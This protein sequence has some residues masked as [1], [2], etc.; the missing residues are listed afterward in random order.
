M[1]KGVA[2]YGFKSGILPTARS[3]LKHPTIKQTSLLDKAN[4]PKPKGVNGLGY[5]E[6]IKHPI[7][8]KRVQDPIKFIDVEEVIAKTVPEPISREMKDL[9][10]QQMRRFKR[11]E[12]RRDYLSQAFRHEEERLLKREEKLK[13]REELIA[14]ERVKK[15]EAI[16]RKKQSDLTIPSLDHLVRQPL[17]RQRTKEENELLAMKRKYN[18]E[19]IEFKAK[20]RKL[21]RLIDL[22]YIT[23]ELIVNEEQLMKKLDKIFVTH[24]NIYMSS[25]IQ[26]K[27]VI[28]NKIGDALFGSVNEHLGLPALKDFISGEAERFAGRVTETNEHLIHDQKTE[29]DKILP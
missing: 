4:A 5:A 21:E 14:K 22:Y 24:N 2:K 27:D 1:G 15:L 9:T 6:G 16:N 25:D 13:E 20:E 12:L 7:D 19:M 18:R 26:R 29:S 11:A 8:S 10:P 3:I 28:E 23:D 17:M